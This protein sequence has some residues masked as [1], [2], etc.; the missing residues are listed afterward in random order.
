M[1]ER[2]SHV[3]AVFGGER[4]R[5]ELLRDELVSFEVLAGAPAMTVLGHYLAGGWSMRELVTTLRFAH[6][7]GYLRSGEAVASA[8]RERGPAI[9][10]QLAARVLEAALMGVPPVLGVFDE[11][12]IDRD[13]AAA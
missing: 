8:L 9:Y 13:E 2:V 3:D 6:P 4:M 11:A 5:F 12:S 10:L 1:N 7:A